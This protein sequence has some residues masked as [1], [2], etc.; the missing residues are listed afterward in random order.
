LELIK[1]ILPFNTTFGGFFD[2]YVASGEEDP[3][4]GSRRSLKELFARRIS[5]TG[6]H[7]LA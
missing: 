6:H 2:L 5:K 3:F 4:F 1:E 7:Q